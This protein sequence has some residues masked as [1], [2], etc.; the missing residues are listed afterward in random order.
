MILLAFCTADEPV[1]GS[2]GCSSF[3]CLDANAYLGAE[4]TGEL[5]FNTVRCTVAVRKLGL[6]L[7]VT[8]LRNKRNISLRSD[9]PAGGSRKVGPESQTDR[10]LERVGRIGFIA[11]NLLSLDFGVKFIGFGPYITKAGVRNDGSLSYGNGTFD[12][13]CNAKEVALNI[14]LCFFN[15]RSINVLGNIK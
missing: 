1:A 2:E 13:C 9:H 15:T 5:S 4:L 7:C 8:E 14:R 6:Y 3:F 11:P 10:H 12:S